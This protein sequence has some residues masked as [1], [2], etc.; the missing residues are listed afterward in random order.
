MLADDPV[1]GHLRHFL[2]VAEPLASWPHPVLVGVLPVWSRTAYLLSELAYFA[3][4]PQYLGVFA[5]SATCGHATLGMVTP[6]LNWNNQFLRILQFQLIEGAVV[7]CE[8]CCH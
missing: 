2:G 6:S 4:N 1:S 7:Q 8:V 5:L 3:A